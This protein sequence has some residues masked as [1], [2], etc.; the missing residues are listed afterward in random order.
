MLSME[1]KYNEE[2]RN[3][4]QRKKILKVFQNIVAIFKIN[5]IDFSFFLFLYVGL[6]GFVIVA[7]NFV[8]CPTIC[9]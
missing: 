8:V 5:S 1:I 9:L 2:I 4:K 3:I 6:L 7:Y